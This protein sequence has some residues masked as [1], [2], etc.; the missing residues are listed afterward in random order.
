MM[1]S[2]RSYAASLALCLA[3]QLG[4]CSGSDSDNSS[5]FSEPGAGPTDTTAPV[6]TLNGNETIEVAFGAVYGDLGASAVDDVDGEVAVATEGSV[7]T[8]ISGEYEI[9]YSASDASGNTGSRIRTVVV[10]EDPLLTA[11][12]TNAIAPFDAFFDGVLIGADYWSTEPEILSAGLGFDGI[13][14][15]DAPQLTFD[16][17]READGTWAQDIDCGDDLRN[18]TSASLLNQLAVAYEQQ[19]PYGELKDGA[20]GIDGLPIV[21]SWP[22]DTSTV[23]LSDFQVTLNTGDIVKPL[24]VS[25]FPNQEH[26]ERNTIPIFGEWGNR[27]PSSEPNSRYPVKVEI[28]ADETPLMLVG[29]GNVAVSAVGLSWENTASPYDENNGPRLVGAKLNRIEGPMQGEGPGLPGFTS[30]DASVLY[31]E[32]DFQLRM[33]TSG[34]YSPDG[35]S[36]VRPDEFERYFRIH[37]TGADGNTVIIDRVGKEY[38]VQGGRLRVVGLADPAQPEGGAVF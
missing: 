33:L 36:G 30:N 20:I 17:V 28:V 15:L 35:V 1:S 2:P 18:Y 14:G 27:L 12:I 6:I 23:N 4:G 10:L 3:G 16:L 13:I 7:D 21:F 26:N 32:G 25:P 19:T 11:T 37:A 34:G 5:A 38:D 29:P 24:A 8:Q 31:D 9:A 22:V